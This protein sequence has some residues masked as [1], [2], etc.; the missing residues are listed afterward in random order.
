MYWADGSA[1][2]TTGFTSSTNHT[3]EFG[4]STS[5]HLEYA[6]DWTGIPE[7]L[8]WSGGQIYG[9]IL[10]SYN[11]TITQIVTTPMVSLAN[12]VE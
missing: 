2:F 10:M 3:L 6:H 4:S 8:C 7:E 9:R 1:N 12:L 11:S 5:I